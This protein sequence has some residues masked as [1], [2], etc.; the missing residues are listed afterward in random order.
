MKSEE[1]YAGLIGKRFGMLVITGYAAPRLRSNGRKTIVALYIC[2]CGKIGESL[3]TTIVNRSKSCGCERHKNRV[4][5]G[6][7]GHRL[8]NI[9]AGMIERCTNKNHNRYKD[10]GGRG[11][12]VCKWWLNNVIFFNW[13]LKNGYKE[14][15][16]LERNDV[17][18]NYSPFNCSWKTRKEQSRNTRKNVKIEINGVT[19]VFA[20]W[21]E[22]YGAKYKL[23][24]E[25]MK[26]GWV[27]NHD[28]FIKCR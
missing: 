27:I 11:I 17:N 10:Y 2:D 28:F 23:A 24:H 6:M 25:R 7:T 15:L 19:K 26:K 12:K 3:L 18:G 16:T 1:Y 13:A 21:C 14:D 22:I 9:W 8:Y 5:H 20:E 4:T